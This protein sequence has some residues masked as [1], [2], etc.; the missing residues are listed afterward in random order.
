MP[1]LTI[2]LKGD[3]LRKHTVTLHHP[4]NLRYLKLLHVNHNVTSVDLKVKTT[5]D[6]S[7][8]A[9]SGETD[10]KNQV[11][12]YAKMACLTAHDV[13]YHENRAGVTAEHTV[14]AI[15]PSSEAQGAAQ[16]RDITKLLSSRPLQIHQPFRVEIYLHDPSVKS[17][18]YDAG[19]SEYSIGG[20]HD[21][22]RPIDEL[23]GDGTFNERCFVELTF[24][25]DE[26]DTAP[27]TH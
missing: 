15:G 21:A 24:Q 6:V 14:F 2:T 4:L 3:Q 20:Y 23:L 26:Y 16:W 18:S 9:I 11:L 13:L 25:Y 8:G 17:V 12:L 19:R 5:V 10:P 7:T 1:L 27:R 22:L